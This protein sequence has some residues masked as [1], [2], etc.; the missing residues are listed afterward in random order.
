[1]PPRV[2]IALPVR[3]GENFLG[4][5][6][7]SIASQ[8]LTDYELLISDNASTDRTWAIIQQHG[9]L[10]PRI[11]AERLDENVGAAENF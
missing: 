8:T 6:L 11:R 5:A 10:D 7:S 2:T 1:M 4:R 9:A 3:N